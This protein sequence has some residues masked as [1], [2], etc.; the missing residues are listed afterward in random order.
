MSKLSYQRLDEILELFIQQTEP[1]SA[2]ELSRIHHV[3]E[4]TIRSDINNLNEVLQPID[5]SITTIRKKGYQLKISDQNVFDNWWN[6]NLVASNTLLSSSKER[7]TL[8][9]LTLFNDT[10]TYSLEGFLE[11]LYVSKNTFYSYLK[12][13]REELLPYGLKVINRPNLGFELVGSEFYKRQAIIDLLVGK[14]LQEYLIGFT[15]MEFILFGNI[16]VER[17]KD[18][19]LAHFSNLG[20]LES[21]YYHKNILTHFALGISRVLNQ[22]VISEFP[23]KTP[24]LLPEANYAISQFSQDIEKNYEVYLPEEE[25]K[26]FTYYL[27]A[28]APRLVKIRHEK[29][30]FQQTS[31]QIVSELLSRVKQS[32]N[33][34]WTNDQLL[35]EDLTSHINGFINM[36]LIDT[37][38]KNPLLETIRCAFPLAYDLCLTNLPEIG[39]QYGLYFSE[40]EIGYIALHFAGALERNTSELPERYRTILVCGTGKAMSRII[41]AKLNKTYKDQIQIIKRLSF[42][43]L[44]QENLQQI[45]FVITTVP[46]ENIEVPYIYIDMTNLN[47]EIDK[48]GLYIK[49]VEKQEQTIKQLFDS[50]FFFYNPEIKTKTELLQ[51]MTKKLK[52][53]KVVPEYFY[54]SIMKRENIEQTSI[55]QAI[56]IPH[57]MSLISNDTKLAVAILPDGL[58]WGENEHI[59]FVFLFAIRKEDY[60]ET[61]EIYNLLVNFLND[62]DM[63]QQLLKTSSFEKF[64]EQIEEL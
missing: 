46:L 41:E 44:Q 22:Q 12:N 13:I 30:T 52:M 16:D 56:A 17:L 20:L 21:D 49:K 18:I 14:D 63:Q 51:L 47:C 45:D 9:L 54:Q 55:G 24:E 32:S 29:N 35:I 28:N 36:N 62:T 60:E 61:A 10:K 43:E 58:K 50:R 64:L 38:R 34:D 1:I 6:E 42:V 33:F 48:V 27:A 39:K 8:L 3:T 2:Q 5:S 37:G 4:R 57:P 11:K 7:Q 25:K 59:F 19:E 15:E 23:V 40:D 31:A 53:K 26:Y